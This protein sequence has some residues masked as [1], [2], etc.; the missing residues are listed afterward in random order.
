ML[1]VTVF[2]AEMMQHGCLFPP[3]ESSPRPGQREAESEWPEP[4]PN[5]TI[6]NRW[7]ILQNRFFFFQRNVSLTWVTDHEAT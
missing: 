1:P 4:L 5:T 6:S 2:Q 3:A 7:I